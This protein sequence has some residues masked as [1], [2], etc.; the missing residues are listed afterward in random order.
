M[1]GAAKIYTKEKDPLIG[2]VKN[3]PF[4]ISNLKYHADFQVE[5]FSKE[6]DL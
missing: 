4:D 3:A 6:L 1:G 5:R 2:H